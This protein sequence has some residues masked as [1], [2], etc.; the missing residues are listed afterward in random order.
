MT[1]SSPL[2]KPYLS[3]C[4]CVDL[5]CALIAFFMFLFPAAVEIKTSVVE[6]FSQL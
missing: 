1:L 5:A 3:G 2:L 6:F 4:F